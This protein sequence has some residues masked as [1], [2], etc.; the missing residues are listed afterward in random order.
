MGR[1]E[2]SP[3]QRKII[4]AYPLIKA[5]VNTG[6]DFWLPRQDKDIRGWVES[7]YSHLRPLRESLVAK[8]GYAP[9]AVFLHGFVIDKTYQ[10]L[11]P[12]LLEEV[13][14]ATGD[15]TPKTFL[16][17]TILLI[18]YE[19]NDYK[20]LGR[21]AM[22]VF[23]KLSRMGLARRWGENE[24]PLQNATLRAFSG[25]LL[26]G[27]SLAL[28]DHFEQAQSKRVE[29]AAELDVFKRFICEELRLDDI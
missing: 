27:K 25:L 13:V 1:P 15:Q 7:I 16:V 20:K 10:G 29:P 2:F 22:P 23:T 28:L 5:L 3:D 26:A 21:V 9:Y 6:V 24:D 11:F 4:E 12:D 8:M 14:E 19:V 18:G 17:E